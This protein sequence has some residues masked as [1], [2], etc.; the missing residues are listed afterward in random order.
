VGR[1][2]RE[3]SPAEREAYRTAWRARQRLEDQALQALASRTLTAAR[4][5]A[6]LLRREYG[7][8][9]VW[10]FGSLSRGRFGPRSDVDLAVEGLAGQDL[11]RAHAQVSRLFPDAEVDLVP[12]EE[13]PLHLQERI[14]GEGI[15]L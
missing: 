7:A 10:L 13:A 3:L 5:A 1:T 11:L 14:V 9:R 2:A 6:A 12:L 4:E 8:R 15:P